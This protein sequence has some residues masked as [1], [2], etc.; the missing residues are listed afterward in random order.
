MKFH[1]IMV[2][3][4]KELKD[5]LRD[6]RTLLS[7]I[8]FPIILMPL[9][10]IGMTKF[11]VSRMEKIKAERSTIVWICNETNDF[12]KDKIESL[13]AVEVIS[14]IN[15][16]SLALEMLNEKDIDAVVYIPDGFFSKLN[17]FLSNESVELP[18]NIL[19]YSDNTREKCQFV[20]RTLTNL[21]TEYRA[22]IV[23][24]ALKER[25]LPEE[26]VRPF[27]VINQNT[28]SAE[29][30]G[31]SFAGSFLPYIVILMS[32]IGAMYPAID[33]T[34]GE[35]ERGTLETLLV[36]G[37]SRMDI[38]IGKFLTVFS[39][40]IVTTALAVGSLAV[41]G[42]GLI[43]ISPE[44]SQ[45][46]HFSIEPV[47]VILMILAMIP[48]GAIFASLMM[49]LSLFARS[50]RE[51]QSYISPLMIVIILPAMASLMPDTQLNKELAFVPVLNVSMMMKE[52]LI[53]SYEVVTVVV[54]MAVNLILALI[55]LIIVLQM[56][57]RES[58]LFRT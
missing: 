23:S 47:G 20:S 9:M 44:Q 50:Y 16:T 7:M 10:T 34:A 22:E 8:L 26:L 21:I 1:S 12:L 36:S 6:R 15:D 29:D 24:G 19:I 31:R 38:V 45:Q 43:G 52:A 41:S 53:G 3:Y 58:V 5:I 54:T 40:S 51:A 4:L 49:T 56:F 30:M 42:A 39:T 25:N 32:L 46:L 28:A 27:W 57:Q 33:L 17:M 37:V 35:K 18:P 55:G 2:V 48:L 11:M 14:T 13:E